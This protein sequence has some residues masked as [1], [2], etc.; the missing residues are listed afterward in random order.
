MLRKE[1]SKNTLNRYSDGHTRSKNKSNKNLNQ[2]AVSYID[3]LFQINCT[4][5]STAPMYRF[6]QNE[7]IV[8]SAVALKNSPLKSC[9]HK[10]CCLSF[11]PRLTMTGGGAS[12]GKGLLPVWLL[13][14]ASTWSREAAALGL[15][16]W[17][18]DGKR[19]MFIFKPGG[20]ASSTATPR[21]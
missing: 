7:A 6:A 12:L 19:I 21:S 15:G 17:K 3:R 1:E 2:T 10:G 16:R 11:T 18:V 20:W 14:L 8:N 9:F 4:S 5:R 13:V